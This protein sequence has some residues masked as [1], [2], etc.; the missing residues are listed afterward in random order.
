MNRGSGLASHQRKLGHGQF[1]DL[2][3]FF[4]AGDVLFLNQSRVIPARLRG[5][6]ARMAAI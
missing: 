1:R 2:P 3:G 5:A 6:N 4:R